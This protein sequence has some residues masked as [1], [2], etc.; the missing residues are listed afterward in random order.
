MPYVR[1]LLKINL[2]SLMDEQWSTALAFLRNLPFKGTGSQVR[3]PTLGQKLFVLG[4][5]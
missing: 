2:T 3:I 5:L 4:V 1:I